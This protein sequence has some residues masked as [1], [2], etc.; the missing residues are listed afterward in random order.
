MSS[1]V[2]LGRLELVD[3][4]AAWPNEASNFT[5]WLAEEHNLALLGEALGLQ[6]QL[7]AVEKPVDAFSADILAKDLD[8]G[9]LVLVENQLEQTDHTHLGQILTYAAGLGAQTVVWIAATFRE[10]HRAAVDY[11]NQISAEG[12][13]FF[14]V[15]V[16]LY[17]I[18]SSSYAPRFTLVAK[19][20]DWSKRLVARTTDSAERA[21]AKQEWVDYWQGF[22]ASSGAN[23]LGLGNRV[24]PKEGWCR[25]SQLR[26]GDPRASIWAHRPDGKLRTVLWL[27]G[28][29]RTD[30]FDTLQRNS[31]ALQAASSKALHWDRMDHRKSSMIW[32]ENGE[33][34]FD[35]EEQE[36][37]WLAA[38]AQEM[39][40]IFG[41]PVR[42]VEVNIEQS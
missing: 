41:Q 22:F 36:Y 9:G 3:L 31:S 10:P 14:G 18:G 26:S 40:S 8:T 21:A 17:R 39:A 7:E 23:D 38:T 34:D 42:D 6:L 30:L 13:N 28:V 2:T 27:E 37:A 16:Q 11:L 19:P 4:R 12:H 35:T 32:I 25:L 1:I 24:P 15:Q 20:N 5:P 33:S 29:F